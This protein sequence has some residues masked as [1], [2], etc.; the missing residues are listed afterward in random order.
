M[1]KES[2]PAKDS[3]NSKHQGSSLSETVYKDSEGASRKINI[4]DR[5]LLKSPISVNYS[6]KVYRGID[7]NLRKFVTI[8]IKPVPSNL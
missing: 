5:F 3:T 7:L 8:Y 6:C 2:R 4:N 1:E